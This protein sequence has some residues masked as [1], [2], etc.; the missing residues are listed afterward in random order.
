MVNI[1]AFVTEYGMVFQRAESMGETW[2][3]PEHGL[4]LC[5][6]DD[7]QV[8]SVSLAV[9]ADI[10]H[11]ILNRSGNNSY[12]LALIVWWF[13]EVQSTKNSTV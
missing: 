4:V 8:L 10:N 13:L 12:Q 6:Q 11:G 3:N 9:F 2:W 7:A 5:R 1:G